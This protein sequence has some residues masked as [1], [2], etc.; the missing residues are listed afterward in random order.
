MKPQTLFLTIWAIGAVFVLTRLFLSGKK[1]LSIF[2][3]IGEVVVRYRDK[4]G[5]GRSM[6]SWKTKIG[7]AKNVLD[8]VVTDKE[9]WL[10]GMMLFAGVCERFDLL[11]KVPLAN[12]TNV[13]Q[14]GIS[15]TI[16]FTSVDGKDKQLV[17][18]TKRPDAFVNA[19]SSGR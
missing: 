11:H 18:V 4:T 16:D 2:P 7:G 19:I 1:A 13:Q 3:D 17:L 9:L 8:I 15:I 12:I 5:S 14:D 10:K 6:Q